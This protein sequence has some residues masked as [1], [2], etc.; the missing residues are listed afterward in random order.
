[1]VAHSNASYLL[2]ALLL[3]LAQHHNCGSAGHLGVCLIAA[4][5]TLNPH[6]EVGRDLPSIPGGFYS[7]LVLPGDGMLD[8]Q[9]HSVH[10]QQHRQEAGVL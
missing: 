6:Y 9:L 10:L 3:L 2:T 4:S 8:Q 5:V 1:M 7:M